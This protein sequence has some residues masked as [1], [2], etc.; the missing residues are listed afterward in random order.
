MNDYSQQNKNSVSDYFRYQEVI[1]RDLKNTPTGY[2]ENRENKDFF[3]N[4]KYPVKKTA[5]SK[6]RYVQK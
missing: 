1:Q 3:D 2:S 5:F 4:K 6:I